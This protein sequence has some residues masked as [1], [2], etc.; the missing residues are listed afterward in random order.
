MAGRE[1]GNM[2]PLIEYG[3]SFSLENIKSKKVK[4]SKLG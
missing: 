3:Q 1:G 4:F 2:Y